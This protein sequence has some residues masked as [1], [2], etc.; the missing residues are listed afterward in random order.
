MIAAYGVTRAIA[1]RFDHADYCVACD[2]EANAHYGYRRSRF[3]Q[4][5]VFIIGFFTGK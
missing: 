1:A 2:D 5:K 4:F 3:H